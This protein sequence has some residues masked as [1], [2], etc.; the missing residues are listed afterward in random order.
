MVIFQ[1]PSSEF[2]NVSV[3]DVKIKAIFFYLTF[4]FS[5]NSM[6]WD[7]IVFFF[8]ICFHTQILCNFLLLGK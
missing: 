7:L 4:W 5:F 2:G 3:V 8:C 6:I 1:L